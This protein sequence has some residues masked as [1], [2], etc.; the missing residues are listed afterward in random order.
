MN[1]DLL[2][3]CNRLELKR[4]LQDEDSIKNIVIKLQGLIKTKYA[5]ENLNISEEHVRSVLHW[6]TARITRI[7]DLVTSKFG[8]LW[9]LPSQDNLEVNKTLLEKLIDNLEGIDKFEQGTLKDNLKKFSNENGIKFP[10]LMK[11]L[12]NTLSGL[13]EGPSVAEMLQ[14]LGK[15]QSLERIKAVIR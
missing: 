7:E 9:I 11:M 15:H 12:R 6:A 8:F 10:D 1:P 5:K 14:L 4:Q 3:E 2:E 13:S